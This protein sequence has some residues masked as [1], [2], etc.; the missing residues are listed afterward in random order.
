MQ[1][2]K[3]LASIIVKILDDKKATDIEVL[4]VNKSTTLAD[5]FVICTGTSTTQIKA[6]ADEVEFRLKNEYGITP[7]HVE[8]YISAN[9]ILLDYSSVV[10]HVF[11]KEMREF[12][13]LERLWKDSPKITV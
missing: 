5:F 3:E 9:W 7:H 1:N 10:V 4:D 8:G 11:H 13:A 2:P 12:Y 6:L